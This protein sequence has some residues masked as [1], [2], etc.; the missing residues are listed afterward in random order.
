MFQSELDTMEIIEIAYKV[1][2]V[3]FFIVG[4]GWW[5][6][7]GTYCVLGN[8]LS[9]FT[10]K[11]GMV[12]YPLIVVSLIICFCGFYLTLKWTVNEQYDNISLDRTTDHNS[13]IVYEVSVKGEYVL[14]VSGLLPIAKENRDVIYSSDNRTDALFVYN[15]YNGLVSE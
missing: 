5:L 7:W 12:S 9:P 6:I 3:T 13:D 15:Y 2:R 4:G 11:D 1:M 14:D 8:R 10:S